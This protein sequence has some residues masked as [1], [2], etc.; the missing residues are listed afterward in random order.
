MEIIVKI[1]DGPSPT[2][3]QDGDVVRAI[4]M[5]DIYYCHAQHKCH[6]KNFGFTTG[7]MRIADPL[8]IKFL[9]KTRV[10]KFERLNSNDVKRINLT[11][12]EESVLNNTPNDDGE[13]IDVQQYISR[14]LNNENHLMF[15][16]SG[17]EYWYGKNR[18]DIDVD[19]IWS[20]IET[21]TDFLQSDHIYFPL[22][23]I[24]KRTFLPMSCCMHSHAHD[25]T[26]LPVHNACLN[27]TCGCALSECDVDF[28]SDRSASIDIVHNEGTEEEY[29]ELVHKRK[30]QV[31]YWDLTSI[32]S[33]D[34]DD[35]RNTNKEVDSRKPLQER[36]A[37]D[38][39][40][41]DKIAAGIVS[42]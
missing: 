31:P 5:S 4:S 21:H 40:T 8:L 38:L 37:A 15:M 30:Y 6:V 32:L 1:N 36:S 2:S 34:I 16:S 28:V 23:D 18:G 7:G 35:I 20:D 10:Y 25:H 9:E 14:R 19:S 22:S 41:V 3:Y 42:V 11:T 27:V 29:N 26:D 12:S 39:L 17:L 33:L 24:E 13:R